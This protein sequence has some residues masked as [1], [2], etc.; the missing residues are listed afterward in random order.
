MRGGQAAG[1]AGGAP[2]GG[3]AGGG[4]SRSEVLAAGPDPEDAAGVVILLHGRGGSPEGM[5][6]LA[7]R[8]APDDVAVL[9]PRA[10]RHTWYP[11]SFLAPQEENEPWLSSALSW[12]EEIV[13]GLAG[14]ES[15]GEGAAPGVGLVGF[16]QG[17]CLALEYAARH[18]R[19]YGGVA[20][21]SG[22][23]VGPPGREWAYEGSLEGTPVF[24]GCSDRD[25]H[26]PEE[27][28]RESGRVLEGL[29]ADVTVEIYPGMGHTVNDDE[30][31]RVRGMMEGLQSHN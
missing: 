31:E 23:L 10:D 9:A 29:G 25:P 18:P 12:L 22:G 30:T 11:R 21:L 26:I 5:L 13:E 7:G 1:S 19:R 27:R 14:G 8:I 17:A 6:E 20:G 16:S 15:G 4:H 24:L 3:D 28:V 2:G